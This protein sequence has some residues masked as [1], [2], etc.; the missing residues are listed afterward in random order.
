MIRK[1][2]V[3]SFC[4]LEVNSRFV[5][6]KE[7]KYFEC[8]CL[9]MWKK[10][11]SICIFSKIIIHGEITVFWT[12]KILFF[13]NIVNNVKNGREVKYEGFSTSLFNIFSYG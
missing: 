6:G 12:E 2:I 4:Q 13:G 5:V 3:K 1:Y 9:E 10:G 11:N 7:D 8:N